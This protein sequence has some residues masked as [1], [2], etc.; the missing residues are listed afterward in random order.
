MTTDAKTALLRTGIIGWP[1]GHSRSPVIHSYWIAKY[2]IDGAY[3]RYGVPPDQIEAFLSRFSDHG[4]IGCNVTLP[5][6]QAAFAAC[7]DVDEV[8]RTL[9]AV[10]TLW[11]DEGRLHGANTDAYG[12]LANLDQAAPGWDKNPGTAVVLGAGGA[13]RAIV[14]ALFSRGFDPVRIVNRTFE[15]A[16]SLAAFFGAGTRAHGWGDLP[17][18]LEKAD[19]LVNSTSLGMTGKPPLEID[20]SPLRDTCLVAD[21]VYAPLETGLLKAARAR[22]LVAVDGLGMLLHQA[23]PSFAKWFGKVPE[24]TDELR[25]HVVADLSKDE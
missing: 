1:V 5:H 23:V 25:A 21:A 15:K 16:E 14:W 2:G 7:D 18:V 17:S 8:G 12:F 3:D 6:K 24:V 4:L 20:L 19:I 9:E 22:D 11:L 13:A 10:N